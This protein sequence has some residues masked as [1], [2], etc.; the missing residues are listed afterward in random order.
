[1]PIM[2]SE[3]IADLTEHI[4]RFGGDFSAW[5]VGT[6]QDT[7]NP[8]FEADRLKDS[9]DDDALIYREAYT[10]ASARAV[11]DHFLNRRQ[12]ATT[13]PASAQSVQN[14]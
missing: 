10:P 4:R 11:R 5:S 8:L 9:D 12:Q 2:S 1:M 14:K 13:P 7:H 3:I 6:A